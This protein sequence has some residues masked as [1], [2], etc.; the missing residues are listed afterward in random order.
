M[1]FG[2]TAYLSLFL[3]D[4]HDDELQSFSKGRA[5]LFSEREMACRV[6]RLGAQARQSALLI[7][8]LRLPLQ[9]LRVATGRLRRCLATDSIRQ[10]VEDRRSD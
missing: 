9:D 2:Q 6:E 10:G 3:H 5:A 4:A 8:R 1:K 7:R